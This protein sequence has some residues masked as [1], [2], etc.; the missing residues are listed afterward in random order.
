MGQGRK[1]FCIVDLAKYVKSEREQLRRRALASTRVG[2]FITVEVEPF[3]PNSKFTR[4]ATTWP[5]HERAYSILTA[6]TGGYGP[7]A[8]DVS[9]DAQDGAA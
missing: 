2:V 4:P 9:C 3:E 6:L 7:G 1:K 5:F 8:G